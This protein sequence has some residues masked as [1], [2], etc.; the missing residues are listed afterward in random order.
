[1]S[2]SGRW[3]MEQMNFG[4]RQWAPPT[5][6]VPQTH[7]ETQHRIPTKTYLKDP[8]TSDQ[9]TI[10][11][12][13]TGWSRVRKSPQP[14]HWRWVAGPSDGPTSGRHGCRHGLLWVRRWH[15]G[16]TD[17]SSN[18]CAWGH[19]LV[20]T[21]SL[22]WK[23]P[24][25]LRTVNRLNHLFLWAIYT[26]AMSVITRWYRNLFPS[27]RPSQDPVDFETPARSSSTLRAKDNRAFFRKLTNLAM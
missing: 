10:Y 22:P 2:R 23:D 4:S 3:A 12:W 18:G 7:Q 16:E 27:S 20:T 6:P 5:N 8:H 26:M 24:P 17:P 25:F 14:W 13:E 19:H 21:K 9:S 11:P 15:L 1:M